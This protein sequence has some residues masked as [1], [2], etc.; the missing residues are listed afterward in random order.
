MLQKEI[1][2]NLFNKK[3]NSIVNEEKEY[4]GLNLD[5]LNE[6]E[7]II[8]K[9]AVDLYCKYYKKKWE[10]LDKQGKH[11]VVKNMIKDIEKYL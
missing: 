2:N 6:I 7:T 8:V 5:G 1:Y 9:Q 11:D 4:K 3:T 10:S